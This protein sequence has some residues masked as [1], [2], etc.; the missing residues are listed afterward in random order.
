MSLGTAL[1][2]IK[3][4]IKLSPL[5]FQLHEILLDLYVQFSFHFKYFKNNNLKFKNILLLLLFYLF[6]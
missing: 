5:F 6:N 2:F 4:L 3:S 1:L